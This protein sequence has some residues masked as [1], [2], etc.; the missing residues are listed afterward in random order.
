MSSL[1]SELSN[2]EVYDYD[3]GHTNRNN[4]DHADDGE[5]E[6]GT[7][8]DWEAGEEQRAGPS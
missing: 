2:E 6:D 8:A 3:F 5:A 4:F 7:T 1:D